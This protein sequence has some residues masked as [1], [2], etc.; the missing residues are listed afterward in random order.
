MLNCCILCET[1]IEESYDCC[2]TVCQQV[3]E[4]ERRED[5]LNMI[6]WEIV[7]EACHLQ[8]QGY[9]QL[10]TILFEIAEEPDNWIKQLRLIRV[11]R[12]CREKRL[13]LGD[14]ELAYHM[15]KQAES[16]H[17]SKKARH[18]W[19]RYYTLYPD[20]ELDLGLL[21]LTILQYYH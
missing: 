7:V 6:P 21:P 17:F 8:D 20:L 13:P 16:P 14:L 3:Y 11:I 15:L 4:H 12:Y 18:I 19:Q 9:H 1:P 10:Y 2:S 5:I